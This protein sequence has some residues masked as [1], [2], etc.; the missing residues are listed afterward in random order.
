MGE[1]FTAEEV[2]GWIADDRN[3]FS[4]ELHLGVPVV[5]DLGTL[6][7]NKWPSVESIQQELLIL[8]IEVDLELTNDQLQFKL[9]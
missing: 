4:T 8:G 5:Y 6:D 3:A 9:R 2:A 1:Q 7:G